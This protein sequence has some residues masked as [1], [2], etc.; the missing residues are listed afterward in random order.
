MFVVYLLV[1]LAAS[2]IGAIS[3]VGGGVMIKPIFDAIS[4]YDTYTVGMLSCFGVLTMSATSV[5]KQVA[6]KAKIQLQTALPLAVGAV[7]GG[8]LG[9]YLFNTVRQSIDDSSIKIAQ[10]LILASFLVFVVIYMNRTNT[11][12]RKPLIKGIV[13][14]VLTGLL[15]GMVSTFIGIGGGPINIAVLCL[16]FA[17][18]MKSATVNSLVLIIFS[19]TSKLIE[20]MISGR[21]FEASLPWLLILFVCLIASAGGMIG[22]KINRKLTSEKI[23]RVYTVT[24]LAI[25]CI[26]IYNI[27]SNVV[28]LLKG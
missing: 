1:I 5:A 8:L 11:E 14:T 9:N 27:I 21:L 18:D 20:N 6:N 26:N 12:V 4:P 7:L 24:M 2:I 3:G 16:L 25:I 13:P 17:L 28:A 15:L 23:L 10:A 19:Q 22:T